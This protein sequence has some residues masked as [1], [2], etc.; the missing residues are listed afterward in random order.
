[1]VV[2]WVVD[3]DTHFRS[4]KSISGGVVIICLQASLQ[5][6]FLLSFV[7]YASLEG[8]RAGEME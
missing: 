1:M 3:L 6:T 2:V 4:A 5:D 7:V 8:G